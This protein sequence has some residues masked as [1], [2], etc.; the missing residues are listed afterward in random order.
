MTDYAVDYGSCSKP[1][2]VVKIGLLTIGG[3]GG[4][5]PDRVSEGD[6]E[7]GFRSGSVED[8]ERHCRPGTMV[9]YEIPDQNETNDRDQTSGIF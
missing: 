1:A 3:G 2:T 6:E 8:Y 7:S 9:G 4:H 5:D